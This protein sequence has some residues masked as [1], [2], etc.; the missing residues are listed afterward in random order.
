MPRKTKEEYNAYH[1][2]YKRKRRELQRLEN[3]LPRI[4]TPTPHTTPQIVNPEVVSQPT[5]GKYK[6]EKCEHNK[7]KQYC[8][9][10]D[11][12]AYCNHGKLKHNC[13]QCGGC[14][15]NHGKRKQYCKKCNIT[16]QPVKT[17]PCEECGLKLRTKRALIRHISN[18]H[19]KEKNYKCEYCEFCCNQK[20]NLKKHSCYVKREIGE[21]NIT[22]QLSNYSIEYGIQ[23]RLQSE[24]PN[25]TPTITCPFGR[26]DIMTNDT[27]IEI[28]RWDE[29]KKAI[30][31]ILGYSTY[32]PMYKKRI[33]F[34]GRKPSENQQEAIRNVCKHFDIEITEE[35]NNKTTL[36]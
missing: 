3:V 16:Q 7:Q 5:R 27:I 28:K 17:F 29:N 11:G 33:H 24:I 30:G 32:F 13:E 4:D 12:S 35:T 31:Q 22:P 9:Q 21:Q 34:F 15:C 14:I 26:I 2:E 20:Q 6:R 18:I 8:K 10:C 23:V 36:K 25:A 19:K 1:R